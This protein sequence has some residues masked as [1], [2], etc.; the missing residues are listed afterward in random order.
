MLR[1]EHDLLE[2]LAAQIGSL[3]KFARQLADEAAPDFQWQSLVT[4]HDLI[5]PLRLLR[6]P[7]EDMFKP[8]EKR[9]EFYELVSFSAACCQHTFEPRHEAVKVVYL[10]SLLLNGIC[11]HQL[12]ESGEFGIA[13]NC[14]L[15]LSAM[16]ELTDVPRALYLDF[17]NGLKR[18]ASFIS[19]FC[20]PLIIRTSL[21]ATSIT[22]STA[23]STTAELKQELT[24]LI[25]T[26][27]WREAFQLLKCESVHEANALAG[28]LR[29]AVP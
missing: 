16:E 18:Q 6:F 11:C 5:Q 22:L 8:D 2:C 13:G 3:P 24:A 27:E 28:L 7:D 4:E 12:P 21:L 26:H 10:S 23:V 17:V 29:S 9:R 20:R 15:L 14:R 25:E 1:I 19:T